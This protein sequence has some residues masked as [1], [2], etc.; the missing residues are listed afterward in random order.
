MTFSKLQQTNWLYNVE[1]Y[2]TSAD[3]K[4]SLYVLV[5]IKTLPWKFGILNP[6]NSRVI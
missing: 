5:Y 3:L 6:K 4:I 1:R 2:N